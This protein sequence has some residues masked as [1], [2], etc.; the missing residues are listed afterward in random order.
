MRPSRSRWS[1]GPASGTTLVGEHC[2]GAVFEP[3]AQ[4]C[5]AVRGPRSPGVPRRCEIRR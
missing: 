2:A 4:V 5:R 1:G 3:Q